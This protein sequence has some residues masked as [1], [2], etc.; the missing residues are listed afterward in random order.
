MEHKI[1]ATASQMQIEIE[2]LKIAQRRNELVSQINLAL[3]GATNE[4]EILAAVAALAEQNGV[5]GAALAYAE[6]DAT[7][8]VNMVKVVAMQEGRQ[9]VAV[10]DRLP[11]DTFPLDM[12]P[13]LR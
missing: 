1:M 12:N 11:T 10:K 5:A 9:A 4:Q 2:E 7:G 3:S 8:V 6:A 13:I